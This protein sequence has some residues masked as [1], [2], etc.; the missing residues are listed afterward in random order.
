MNTGKVTLIGAGPGDPELMTLKAVRALGEADVV[1]VDD[2]VNREV[3]RHAAGARIVE[4]GKRGGCKSTPQH[5]I[6]RMMIALAQQGQKVARL[7]GGDAFL[8]G[9]GGEEML[10]LRAAG[11][12]MEFV[13]G[14]TSGTAV[15]ATL[16]IP[17]THREYTHGV[18]F[19][20]GHTQDGTPV[21]WRALVE[22]GTTLVIYMG[23]K[24]LPEIVTG[25][26][27]AGMANEMPAAIIQQG[28]LPEQKQV[29]TT[30]ASLPMAAQQE[31]MA[32]PALIVVGDVVSLA[33]SEALTDALKYAA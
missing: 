21:N 17:V 14:I 9:R 33:R 25:L 27:D 18:T 24:N 20:T 28:T 1:L 30:L 29:I 22:G 32:S 16:G 12:E 2:L 10:A 6:N 23:M 19:V 4:V 7:K 3:L 13:P 11:I 26:L 5:F 15:P 31:K 8:F